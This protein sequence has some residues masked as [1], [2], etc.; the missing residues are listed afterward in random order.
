MDTVLEGR[1]VTAVE[2]QLGRPI[3]GATA[4]AHR[5]ECGLPDVVATS[6]RLPDGAPFP[7]LFYLTCPRLTSAV[8]TL[9][10]EGLMRQMQDR[11][12]VDAGLADSYQA[13]HTDYLRRRDALGLVTEIAGTSA[14][15]MPDRVKCLHV[16]VAHSL[17]VG[18][19]V[20]P[21]GDEA[22]RELATRGVLPR[23]RPCVE[24]AD[25]E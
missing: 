9:E 7:T 2:Q 19:G 8:S 23:T 20:N 13:A 22:L 16:M 15:G 24:L 1:D 10:A 14:G 4:V 17:A 12:S 3:R 21:L 5:C 11:L 18:P 6:P 25:D